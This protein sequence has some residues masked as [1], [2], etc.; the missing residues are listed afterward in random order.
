[1]IIALTLMVRDEADIIVP[2]IE[3]HL[4]QGFDHILVTDNASVDGTA[5]ILQEYADR[6]LIH[7]SHD[8][9]HRKQ[10]GVRVTEMA[11]RARTEF[12]ADWVVNG[13]ADEFVVSIDRNL[14]V[15]KALEATPLSLNAFT[16]PVTNLIGHPARHGSGIK[17]LVWRDHRSDE[18][19]QE[20]GIHAQPT[21]NAIHRG[22]PTV[23]VAQGNHFVSLASN[24][25][26]DDAVALEVLHLPWRSWSQFE[27]KV[28]QAGRAYEASPD[29]RPS[30]NHHGMADYRRARAGRLLYAF[31]LRFPLAEELADSTRYQPDTW[32]RDHLEGLVARAHLPERLEMALD[33]SGDAPFTP[34]EHER[35]RGLGLQFRE[36]EAERDA[37]LAAAR[38]AEKDLEKARRRAK[39]AREEADRLRL[40]LEQAPTLA[41]DVTRV[42]RRAVA[43]LRRRVGRT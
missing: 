17:R 6:G 31:L 41:E 15:K 39:R 36:L 32:L 5:E 26:P 27:R 9:V 28:W 14:T 18:D 33:A 42:G 40:R 21:P 35:F 24:G 4:A 38:Q 43:G 30:P 37:A 22:D 13:D 34:E 25:Q 16:V 23:T 3:H 10:Q 19:L 29:L 1:M 7:L 12:A 2:M 11:R 20:I 8:P